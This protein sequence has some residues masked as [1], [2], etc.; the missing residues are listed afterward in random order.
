M[1]YRQAIGIGCSS[2]ATT[3]DVLALLQRSLAPIAPGTVLATLDTRTAL[4]QS[5]ADALGLQLLVF[6]ANKLSQT[7][8]VRTHSEVAREHTGTSSVSEA[9]ALAALG[10]LARLTLPRQIGHLCTCALAVL[11]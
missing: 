3:E 1:S 11:P 9:S 6:S 5:V 2:R 7:P 4:G 10:P 8:G